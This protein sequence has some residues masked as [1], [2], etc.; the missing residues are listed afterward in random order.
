MRKVE[1][2]RKDFLHKSSRYYVDNYDLIALED[3][4]IAEMVENGNTGTI[5]IYT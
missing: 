5:K 4:S 1:N 3:L 2:R